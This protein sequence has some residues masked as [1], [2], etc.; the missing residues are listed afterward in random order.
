M[1]VDA[2]LSAQALRLYSLKA[3]LYLPDVVASLQKRY[4]FVEAP[5]AQELLEALREDTNTALLFKHGK[6]LTPDGRA[7][8]IDGIHL[9]SHL[10][11]AMTSSSTEDADLVVDDILATHGESL[12]RVEPRRHYVSRLEVTLDV[13]LDWAS[14][15]AGRTGVML[16]KVIAGYDPNV[17]SGAYASGFRLV[18]LGM[19]PD[20]SNFQVACDFRVEGRL[21]VAYNENRYF[22][23]APLRTRDHIAVLEALEQSI[24]EAGEGRPA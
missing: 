16:S 6:L 18:A 11:V 13:P 17:P 7:I 22:S 24:R 3:R 14:D 8:L 15:V 5:S 1:K 9:Y 10:V 12:E 20:P 21:G 19:Q 4:G 2:I 23:L